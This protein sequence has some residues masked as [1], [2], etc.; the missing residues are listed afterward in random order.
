MHRVRVRISLSLKY[1]VNEKRT[2]LLPIIFCISQ[3]AGSVSE[4]EE[5]MGKE[6]GK[7]ALISSIKNQ[8]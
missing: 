4:G 5:K 2:Q 6:G 3:L 7:A 1:N 8:I